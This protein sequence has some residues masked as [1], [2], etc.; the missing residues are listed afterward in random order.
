MSNLIKAH[1]NILFTVNLDFQVND[2]EE[3]EIQDII[4]EIAFNTC[5][6]GYK[7]YTV[8]HCDFN[9]RRYRKSTRIAN[10]LTFSFVVE[11]E[12]RV[13]GEEV[14]LT[15]TNNTA[16]DTHIKVI[17]DDQHVVEAIA[18]VKKVESISD[19]PVDKAIAAAVN[20]LETMEGKK[21]Y[22]RA[23]QKALK[24]VKNYDKSLVPVKLNAKTADLTACA[25]ALR[26]YTAQ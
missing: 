22:Y 25:K 16:Y 11:T 4:T 9:A 7:V 19:S 5:L 1:S 3:S 18:P 12:G 17:T 13:D 15:A 24:A 21:G 2:Y 6:E 23:I 14:V 10:Q 8:N 26:K 20:V